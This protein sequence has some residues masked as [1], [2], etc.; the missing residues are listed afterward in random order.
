M[1]NARL[2]P[3]VSRCALFIFI[4]LAVALLSA[5]A[6]LA[7]DSIENLHVTKIEDS[8]I[9]VS[10][11]P[12]SGVKTYQI[13]VGAYNGKRENVGKTEG[14]SFTITGLDPDTFYRITVGG[15]EVGKSQIGVWT[16]DKDEEA[17]TLLS[18]I[19]RSPVTCPALPAQ[20]VVSGN[21][22]YAQCRMIDAGGVGQQDLIDRGFVDAVDIWSIVQG[23]LEVCFRNV[24]WLVFLDAAYSPRMATEL[25]QHQRDGM[26]CGTIDRPGTVLLLSSG[27]PSTA[28]APVNAPAA[29]AAS[30]TLPTFDAIPL[31]DCQ[32]KLVETLFLRAEPAGEIIGLVWLNSE[33]P[34]FEISGDWY[35]IEFE[36]KTGYISRYHRKVLHGGCG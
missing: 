5:N 12:A 8:S 36:G 28:P 29:D 2:L 24:G 18:K 34:V 11:D 26:T 15:K 31:S 10:W 22:Q 1:M 30:A 21:T 16:K 3:P 14:T 13:S 7:E 23:N 20:V 35:N 17:D 32:I 33:V 4:L 9:K 19:N 25:A 27:P 6:A